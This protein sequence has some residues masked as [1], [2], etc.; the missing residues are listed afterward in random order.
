MCSCWIL[1]PY[2]RDNWRH[3]AVPAR[4]AF[5]AVINAIS[6]FERVAVCVRQQDMSSAVEA[7]RQLSNVEIHEIDSD[8]SWI[9]DTG[10]TFLI[11]QNSELRGVHWHFNAWGQL[12]LVDGVN[13]VT[14]EKDKLIGANVLSIAEAKRY[15]AEF[16]L[17]GGS[18]HVD[19]EGT[20]LTTEECL[21]NPN[22]NP[23]LTRED[24][25]V[26]LR[27]HL[28]T[29]YLFYYF[30][31]DLRINYNDIKAICG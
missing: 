3:D 6:Q 20:V 13:Y 7:L 25:E 5:T 16:N 11:G 26:R 1:W 19:G 24:I 9:R 12:G 21:L 10:P 4:V 28:G 23:H 29:N 14:W 2:R 15:R 8:D 27:T 31:F 22:R 17:E 30:Q 18:I